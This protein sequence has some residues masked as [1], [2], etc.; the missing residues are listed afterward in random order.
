MIE[1]EYYRQMLLKHREELH[2][3]TQTGR[4]AADTVELDQSKVGRLTRMDALQAQAISQERERRRTQAL[5]RIDAALQRLEKGDYGY[6]LDC[7]EPIAEQR[8][9]FDPAVTLCIDCASNREKG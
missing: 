1:I 3:L 9:Q 5:H 7:D 2:S 4:E 6:C 8:L